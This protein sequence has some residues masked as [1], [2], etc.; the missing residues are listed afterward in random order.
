MLR[1]TALYAAP[2]AATAAIE[3]SPLR[4]GKHATSGMPRIHWMD[5]KAESTRM[6][7]FV[8]PVKDEQESIVDLYCMISREVDATHSFEVIFVDDGS[9]D[10]SWEVILE[11]A[12][13]KPDHVRGLRFRRNS[14]KSAALSA[15][16]EIARG[17]VVFT[18]DGDL[19]DDPHEIRRF[20]E[21]LDEGYDLVSGWKKVRHDPWHKVWPSRVFNWMISHLGGVPLHDHNCGFKC[22]RAE[23]AKSLSV[24]GDMHR[25]IPS[26]AAMQGYRST[27]IEVLHHPRRHGRSKYGVGR[28]LRG[29]FDMLTIYFLKNFSER[30]A[31]FCGAAAIFLAVL[32]VF[33]C[34]GVPLVRAHWAG[35]VAAGTGA[36]LLASAPVVW[37]LGLVAELLNGSGVR[38]RKLPI[39]EDT[40]RLWP[41]T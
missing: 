32:G 37:T 30:P 8:I 19:Q 16:F 14:G 10:A 20:L 3:A 36:A 23:V 29:F 24:Y 18:L 31:H 25:M 26:L 1:T 38:Q 6:L 5:E 27:E 11:L 34:C 2:N 21:K 17:S 41:C 35:L 40:H 13:T 12:R 28:M 22:Y 33:V 9:R 39:C 15:G 4:D 7:S